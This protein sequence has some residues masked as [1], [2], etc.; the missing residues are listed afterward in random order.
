MFSPRLGAGQPGSGHGQSTPAVHIFQLTLLAPMGFHR[1][2]SLELGRAG[3]ACQ[4]LL[5]PLWWQEQERGPA[6]P[7]LLPAPQPPRPP[8]LA[9]KAAG[10]SHHH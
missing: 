5:P 3:A 7:Q 8:Y 9:V 6:R 4:A 10:V 1:S 2:S